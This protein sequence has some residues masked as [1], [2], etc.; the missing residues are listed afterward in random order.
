VKR[1]VPL[2]VQLHIP[3]GFLNPSFAPFHFLQ[4]SFVFRAFFS[5]FSFQNTKSFSFFIMFRHSGSRGHNSDSSLSNAAVMDLYPVDDRFTL[6][7]WTPQ[8]AFGED[9]TIIFR[10]EE[11][12][13]YRARNGEVNLQNLHF[14]HFRISFDLNAQMLVLG[15]ETSY[16]ACIL[17]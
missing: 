14:L 3:N 5:A 2:W 1:R 6:N 17:A 10:P 9:I 7:R 11:H 13:S 8:L 15:F 4:F 16:N 12:L